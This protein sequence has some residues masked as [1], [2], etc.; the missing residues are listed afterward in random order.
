MRRLLVV[1]GWLGLLALEGLIARS[2]LGLGTWWHWLLHQ[3]VGWGAGLVLAALVGATTRYRV[4][5][6]GAL[7]V[8]Q[9]LSIVPDLLFRF[10]RMPHD[11]SMD[12]WLGHIS[13]HRGPSPT[14]VALVS[15]LVGAAAWTAMTYGQRRTSIGL[16]LAAVV[17]V[18]GACLLAK[19]VP[20]RLADFP[21]NSTPVLG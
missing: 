15:L 8:G 13:I 16:S 17:L 9:V 3:S 12:L 11:A 7:L 21:V 14:V 18:T 10:A 4:P 20:T 6:V 5:V 1:L 19:P 2:Y